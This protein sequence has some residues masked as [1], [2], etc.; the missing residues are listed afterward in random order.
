MEYNAVLESGGVLVG[1]K[2]TIEIDV[3]AALQ[4]DGLIG[5]RHGPQP[6]RAVGA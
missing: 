1:D 3:E 6:R 2:V 5:E 4:Q